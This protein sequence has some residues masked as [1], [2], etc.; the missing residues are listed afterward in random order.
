M[1]PYA[2]IG[3]LAL[4]VALVFGVGKW[5]KSIEARG[6]DKAAAIYAVAALK[7]EETQRGIEKERN[8]AKDQVLKES[9]EREQS[10]SAANTRL[11]NDVRI[12]REREAAYRSRRPTSSDPAVIA[13]RKAADTYADTFSDC[14]DKYREMGGIAETARNAGLACQSQYQSLSI[15]EAIRGKP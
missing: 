7:D 5:E 14:R 12:L 13:E 15:R 11:A 6:Y 8:A 4:V 3:A 10:T 2:L 9:N 1:N